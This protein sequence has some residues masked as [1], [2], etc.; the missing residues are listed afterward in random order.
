MGF[1]FLQKMIRRKLKVF[2]FPNL[3]PSPNTVVSA[4]E[5]NECHGNIYY[6]Q[7]PHHSF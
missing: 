6:K 1:L 5:I 2:M 7:S 4:E 3:V